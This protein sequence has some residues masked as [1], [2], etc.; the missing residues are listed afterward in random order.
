[1]KN[2]EQ[3]RRDRNMIL[4]PNVEN[5]IDRTWEKRGKGRNVLPRGRRLKTLPLKLLV[6]DKEIY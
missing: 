6:A 4:L 5:I 3:I 1:M 2:E